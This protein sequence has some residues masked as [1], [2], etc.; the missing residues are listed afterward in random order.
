MHDLERRRNRTH[1]L[2]I[3]HKL[4]NGGSNISGKKHVL[5]SK[6]THS[7][8]NSISNYCESNQTN[9]NLNK[10]NFKLLF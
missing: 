10:S 7:I 4:Q 3:R 5:I 2:K 8:S 9:S 6:T 1:K